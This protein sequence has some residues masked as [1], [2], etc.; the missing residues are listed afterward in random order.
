MTRATKCTPGIPLLA[1]A[2]ALAPAAGLAACTPRPDDPAPPPASSA[3]GAPPAAATSSTGET[4][5]EVEGTGEESE[6]E[7]EPM[8]VRIEGIDVAVLKSFPVQIH[9]VLRGHLSDPCVEAGEALVSRDGN[10]FTVT[11][12]AERPP[13]RM[14]AQVLVPFER[15][16]PLPVRDLPKGEYRIEAHG[17]S[18]TFTLDRDNSFNP[19]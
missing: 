18:A 2:L 4:G 11:I 17:A 15:S 12:P 1:L 13:G 19:R 10:T 14:C 3:P 9:A 8:L 5:G 7:E 6:A 16:V